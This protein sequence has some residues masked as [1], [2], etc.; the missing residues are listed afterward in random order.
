V[1]D[2]GGYS[3]SE[4]S[5]ASGVSRTT[6]YRAIADGRLNPYLVRNEAGQL[7]LLA[8]VLDAIRG[9]LIR[10]RIDSPWVKP[11][12]K[13][14]PPV[15]THELVAGWANGLI[16]PDLWGPPPWPGERWHTLLV[17]WNQAMD[18]ATE[19]GKFD[20]E[21]WAQLEAEADV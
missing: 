2:P 13:P 9:G 19:H 21:L 3:I 8:T 11:E 17:T 20:A 18:L 15:L 14:K 1:P 4:I 6:L 12:G 10:P 16:D 7:R 5:R